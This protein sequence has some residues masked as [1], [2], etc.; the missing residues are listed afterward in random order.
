LSKDK[1]YSIDYP[2]NV[3][4]RRSLTSLGKL[5]LSLFSNVQISGKDILP[6]KGPVILVG[7]HVSALEAVLM[8]VYTPGIVEFLGTGDIPFDPNY[9]AVVKAYGLVP[10]NRGN[11][12]RKGLQM[13]L[14]VL[15]QGGILGVFPEGGIW[16]PAQMQAQIGAAWLSYR[17]QAPVIPIGFGGMK[18]GLGKALHLR[19]PKLVMNVGDPLPPVKVTEKNGSMK[20]QLQNAS[21]LIMSR[22]IDLVPNE[23]LEIFQKRVDETYQL[24][25]DVFHHKALITIPENLKIEHGPAYARFLFNPTMMDVLVRNLNLPI[26]PIKQVILQFDLE[27]LINAW[28]VIL[29]YLKT[30]PGF[31]T[32]R[33]GIDT[34][35]A[36]K[37]ALIELVALG[38]WAQT[39]G[40]A[41]TITPIQSFRNANTG[42][43]VIET[44]GCF[45]DSMK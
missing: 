44:G 34:G 24:E 15:E 12:D 36:V 10:I 45:P 41:L 37:D 32:Y 11:L 42:A 6:Q 30:N 9:A 1:A 29:D 8:A 43:L 18:D 33:F 26:Q 31:F 4:V 5:I 7:N 16:D 3:F 17:A 2:R 28:E 38:N 35:I 39:S 19:R 25:I 40:Y 27:S 23:D 22:V 21:D 14:D 13:A 20:Q